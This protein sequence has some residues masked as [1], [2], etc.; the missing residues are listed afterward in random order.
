MAEIAGVV[1]RLIAKSGDRKRYADYDRL[2]PG[3]VKTR[4]RCVS[5]GPFTIRDLGKMP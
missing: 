2:G 5:R 3:C 1:I 4:D